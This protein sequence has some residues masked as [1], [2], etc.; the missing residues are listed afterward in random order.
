MLLENAD[1]TH[2]AVITEIKTV[3]LTQAAQ[4]YSK[5]NGPSD[6]GEI[7]YVIM[8]LSRQ[9]QFMLLPA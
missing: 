2:A 4:F 7:S 5:L 1:E 8:L 6:C 3:C 9:E